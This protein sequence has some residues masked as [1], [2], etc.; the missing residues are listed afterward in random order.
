MAIDSITEAAVSSALEDVRSAADLTR[1]P[2]LDLAV[3]GAA[4][5]AVG[6][7]D[8]PEAR[9]WA[10]GDLLDTLVRR[11]LAGVGGAP[12]AGQASRSAALTQVEA[13]YLVDSPEREAWSAIWYRYL[14]AYGLQAKEMAAVARPGSPHGR[15]HIQRRTAL[16]VHLLADALRAAERDALAAR[17]PSPPPT[18]D[19]RAERARLDALLALAEAAAPALN[20]PDQATWLA[21]LGEV[22]G[23]I[24]AALAWSRS[25]GD[26]AVDG[27]RL[28]GLLAP[29]WQLRGHF[30]EGRTQ[31]VQLLE[32]AGPEAPAPARTLA[33]E[34]L[35][36]LAF[37]Q[38]DFQAARR[39][40]EE[41]LALRRALGDAR[42]VATTLRHLGNVAD[43][44]G[45]YSHAA[46]LYAESLATWQQLGD[47]WAAAAVLNNLG[48][49]A[50]RQGDYDLARR[51]LRDS[52]AAFEGL[53]VSWAVGV[54]RANL[55]DIALDT[56]DLPAAAA[57]YRASLAI[58]EDIG[59]RDGQAYAH[60]GL[61]Q[62]E[63]RRGDLAAAREHLAL[64]LALL[65][66]LRN[67]HWLA[68]W[69]EAAAAW[70]ADQGRAE[71]AVRL[72]G[73]ADALRTAIGAP[74][75]PKD[76]PAHAALVGALRSA[77]G[78]ATYAS[79]LA[80][81]RAG[82]WRSACDEALA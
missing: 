6:A 44:I 1:Q 75:T 13:D 81:G 30:T 59:D 36:T 48:L 14:A 10:L 28:G 58:A 32:A 53:G 39:W 8:L 22:H 17:L 5:V 50:L 71:R 16:G 68:E 25:A 38:G 65:N 12:A 35:G 77:L 67:R 78:A 42:G 7:R 60:T 20:G 24:L 4:L 57:D 41:G 55:A 19:N 47:A 45:D 29:Y 64:S 82:G 56:G 15:K 33:L 61:A 31:L 23:S 27:L 21:R 80:A 3:V 46:E 37:Q 73:A 26:A 62:V 66:E 76:Q 34:G 74:R 11:H 40:H 79:A 43:E 51:R 72:L 54:T 70:L 18:L 69:L 9:A 49:V 63:R 2:L 52:L